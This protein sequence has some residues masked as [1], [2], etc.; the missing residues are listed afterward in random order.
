M[1]L[2]T[3]SQNGKLHQ[4][5]FLPVKNISHQLDKPSPAFCL[6]RQRLLDNTEHLERA[7]KRLEHGYKTVLE[8]GEKYG[9]YPIKYANGPAM[10]WYVSA[11]SLP[12]SDVCDLFT[13][14]LQGCFTYT[15]V[16]I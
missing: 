4:L 6:Q 5:F 14:I 2:L 16:I 15:G 3:T 8:T 10:L 11:V 7:G 9:V 12:P 13:Q 1:V